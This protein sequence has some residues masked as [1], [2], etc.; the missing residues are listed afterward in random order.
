MRVKYNRYT[1]MDC[2]RIVTTLCGCNG[3]YTTGRNKEQKSKVKKICTLLLV[4]N[5]LVK[6][7]LL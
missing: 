5:N 2:E 3:L 1:F 6:N 4:K 7:S